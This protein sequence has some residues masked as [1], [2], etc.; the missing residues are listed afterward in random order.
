MTMTV[1]SLHNTGPR[2]VVPPPQYAGLS[3]MVVVHGSENAVNWTWEGVEWP[4]GNPPSLSR[5]PDT[6]DVIHFVSN[7]RGVVIGSYSVGHN[8]SPTITVP[9]QLVELFPEYA[10][11]DFEFEEEVTW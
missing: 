9:E 1:R 5:G 4:D 3:S 2:H 8:A 11:E 10:P 6:Y 7:G